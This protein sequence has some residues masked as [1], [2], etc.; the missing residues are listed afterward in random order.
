MKENLI[1]SKEIESH[2]PY[3]VR[4][5]IEGIDLYI[6]LM[7]LNCIQR[8]ILGLLGIKIKKYKESDKND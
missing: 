8:F 4:I 1:V 3:K 2:I 6:N 5:E 7:K